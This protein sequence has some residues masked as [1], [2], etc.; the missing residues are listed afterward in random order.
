MGFLDGYNLL[1]TDMRRDREALNVKSH[2]SGH[3]QSNGVNIQ[4]AAADN[5]CQF[6]YLF[7]V[8]VA[9]PGFTGVMLMQST[10]YHLQAA[11]LCF[12]W[13]IVSS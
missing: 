11:S 9:V 5:L 4:A 12:P 13:D 1:K 6:S 10:R 7:A 2:Y 8:A 3:Y